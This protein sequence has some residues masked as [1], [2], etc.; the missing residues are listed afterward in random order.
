MS[1]DEREAPTGPEL[2]RKGGEWLGAARNW[3]K[4]HT[5]N[6]D[7]VT[8]GSHDVIEPPFTVAKIEDLAAEVAAAAMRPQPTEKHVDNCLRARWVAEA[9][10]ARLRA[11]VAALKDAGWAVYRAW[12]QGL[13]FVNK[14]MTLGRLS[15]PAAAPVPHARDCDVLDVDPA[16]GRATKPCNCTDQRTSSAKVEEPK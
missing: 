10:V 7:Q 2:L 13:H 1:D 11:E 8:W 9:E 16:I 12:D 6:G 14:M 4:W 5:R 3:L 15:K